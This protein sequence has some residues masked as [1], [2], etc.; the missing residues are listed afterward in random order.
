MEAMT[1]KT[2]SGSVTLV[3]GDVF[4]T[5]NSHVYQYLGIV[6]GIGANCLYL[7][8]QTEKCYKDVNRIWFFDR[9]I[10]KIGA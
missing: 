5:D 6:D 8:D 1:L 3:P 2:R 7:H 4:T 10:K 9:K